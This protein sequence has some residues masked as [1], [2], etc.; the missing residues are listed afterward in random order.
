MMMMMIVRYNIETIQLS[1]MPRSGARICP[2]FHIIVP[3]LRVF[4]AMVIHFHAKITDTLVESRS[5][6]RGV[7]ILDPTW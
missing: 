1:S 2:L 3:S 7:R 4:A 5:F 6:Q